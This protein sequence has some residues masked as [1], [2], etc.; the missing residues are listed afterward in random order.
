[1]V[2]IAYGEGV[3]AAE[4]YN[5]R[6][7]AENVSSIVV[8]ILSISL[9]NLKPMG[10]FFLQAGDVSKISD[11]AKSVWGEVGGRE[12]TNYLKSRAFNPL[13]HYHTE[14]VTKR[15]GLKSFPLAREPIK[16]LYQ[17]K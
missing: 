4:K 8:N 15:F 3:T 9:K 17:P 13:S 14:V 11:K 10:S 6:R 1:M 12:L 16:L 5:G 2:A 7:N